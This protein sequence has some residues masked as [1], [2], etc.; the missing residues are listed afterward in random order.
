MPAQIVSSWGNVVRA[1]HQV[2]R[3]ADRYAAFP[4]NPDAISVL[5]FG[6]G[7]SYG[8]S[9]L[10]VGAGLLHTAA[11]DHFI[12]FDPDSG[13]LACEA[14]TQLT[15]IL[16]LAVPRGWF[17]PVTPGTRFVTVGG[18]I[19]NDVHGKNHHGAGTFSRHVR[20]FELLRSDGQRLVCSPQENAPWFAAT[21]GGLGLTGMITWAEI[22]LRPI[23][24]P[25]MAVE[26]I[27]F[28]NLDEFIDLCA[29]S[30]LHFEY[31][32]AW[33]DC[34]ARGRQLGR[35][36]LQ[37]AN[38]SAESSAGKRRP[39]PLSIP[40]MPPLSLV[41]G[42][43]TRL[44][45]IFNYHRQRNR[46]RSS[47]E[48]FET[49]FYPLDGILHWNRMYGPRG[50]YQYQCVVP[51]AS[52]KEATAALFATIARS[53]LG[54]FLAVL[55]QFGTIESQGLMSFPREGLTLAVDFPNRGE[56][57]E[58]LFR[59]L[60]AIVADA[61]GRLYPAKDGRMPGALFRSGY[62]NW[63]EFSKFIDPGCSSSF[64]RR[65]M[66]DA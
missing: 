47:L 15:D 7:R 3:L 22:Q 26:S 61:G 44:F 34:L 6:N 21:A 32:V 14:G 54:S 27:R 25:A 49:F 66:E 24:G 31:T 29:E 41:N 46:R 23:A 59:E 63:Q 12:T 1:P 10:N 42:A 36:L 38:H 20:R 33:V 30:D 64:W 5:P 58:T 39:R 51:G 50:M 48:P 65:V 28:R 52:G 18:A 56:R 45:N 53:G 19:A 13:L 17:I 37:R 9:C 2:F 60:D 8:D 35:G 4:K 43:S 11:L 40:L 55:K 62:P 57:L 16:N